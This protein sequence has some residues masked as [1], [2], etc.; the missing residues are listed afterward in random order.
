[1]CNYARENKCA[2]TEEYCPYV[3]FCTKRNIWKMSSNAPEKCRIKEQY[4]IPKGYY[5]VQFERKGKLYVVVGDQ[6]IPIANPYDY[7]PV[8][9]KLRKNK[10]GKFYIIKK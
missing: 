4:E 6:T 8:F 7:V 10:E 2:I 9:V 5:K 3:Y 1:M